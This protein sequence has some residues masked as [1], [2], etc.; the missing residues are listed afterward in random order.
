LSHTNHCPSPQNGHFDVRAGKGFRQ[1]Q[2]NRLAAT[3]RV[4]MRAGVTRRIC[5]RA[6][7]ATGAGGLGGGALKVSYAGA[8]AAGVGDGRRDNSRRT[9]S[10]SCRKSSAR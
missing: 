1:F 9:L 3:S 8:A 4:R 7:G 5:G 2:Q 10:S 6:A